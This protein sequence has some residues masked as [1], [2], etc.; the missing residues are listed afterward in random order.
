MKRLIVYGAGGHAKSVVDSLNKR[1]FKLCGFIDNYKKGIFLNYPI[2]SADFLDDKDANKYCYFVAIGDNHIRKEVFKSLISKR[3]DVINIIDSTALISKSAKIGI[4]CYIGKYAIINAAAVICDN[5]ILNNRSLV[6]HE[7]NV[8][9]HV[10]ISTNSVINGGVVVEE[11]AFVGSCS[12]VN[13]LKHIGKNSVIGSGSVVITDV[14]DSS[15]YAGVPAK[16]KKKL[17]W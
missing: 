7:C 12:V 1:E 8:L 2:F 6:E 5:V 9:S 17:E 4:G 3:L 14:P 11:C 10:H 15:L 16:M 13:E